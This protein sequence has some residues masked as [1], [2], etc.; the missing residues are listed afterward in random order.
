MTI[1]LVMMFVVAGVYTKVTKYMDWIYDN[2]Q[3]SLFCSSYSPKPQRKLIRT[4]LGSKFKKKPKGRIRKKNTSKGEKNDENKKKNFFKW[5][6]KTQGKKYKEEKLLQDDSR[7]S[8]GGAP[9]GRRFPGHRYT[10]RENQ[11]K[12]QSKDLRKEKKRN[13]KKSEKIKKKRKQMRNQKKQKKKR[14]QNRKQ[15]N[16]IISRTGPNLAEG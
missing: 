8:G 16:K 11:T 3:Q 1:W 13:R 2:T 15:T 14:E 4:K 12:Q 10:Y 7:K 5:N 6:K 9:A